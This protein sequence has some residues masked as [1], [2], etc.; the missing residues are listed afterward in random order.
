LL[1]A[2]AIPA[3]QGVGA[4]ETTTAAACV[5]AVNRIF[6]SAV[7][8]TVAV[9]RFAVLLATA[10]GRTAQAI[11]F[12]SRFAITIAT[13]RY[14]TNLANTVSRTGITVLA[15]LTNQVT[16]AIDECFIVTWAV[17]V[18]RNRNL[19]STNVWQINDC[20]SVKITTQTHIQP[21]VDCRGA[22]SDVEIACARGQ[23]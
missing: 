3:G 8:T 2:A 5:F 12:Q 22:C 4:L 17:I 15:L 9:V 10:V 21:P 20:I 1:V 7:T 11:F 14:C 16:A 6:A 19:I 18:L 23:E 13:P